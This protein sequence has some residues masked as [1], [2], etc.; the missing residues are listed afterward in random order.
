MAKMV[1]V[2][3]N[4]YLLDAALPVVPFKSEEVENRDGPGKMVG[5]FWCAIE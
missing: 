3:A 5:M 4:A 1:Q 2:F